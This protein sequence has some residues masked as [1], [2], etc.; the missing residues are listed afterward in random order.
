MPDGV[1]RGGLRERGYDVVM[2]VGLERA[3]GSFGRGLQKFVPWSVE[4]VC[5]KMQSRPVESFPSSTNKT[6]KQDMFS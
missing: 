6:W 3:E 2:G 5:L 1:W 4:S